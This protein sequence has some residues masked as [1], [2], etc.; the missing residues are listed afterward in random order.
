MDIYESNL[1]ENNNNRVKLLFSILATGLL[2]FTGVVVETSMNVGFPTLMKEFGV[3]TAT[4]QWITTGYLLVLSVVIPISSYLKKR[5]TLKKLFLTAV[6]LFLTGT[7]LAAFSGSFI[8]LLSGRLIQ[9]VGT[10]IALP[11]MFIIILEQSPREKAG[12]YMGLGN[13]VL[14]LAPAVGP[15]F[16][17]FVIH[18][19]TWRYVFFL[20]LPFIFI[21]LILGIWSI[22]QSSMLEKSV[23]DLRGYIVLASCFFA[24]LFALNQAGRSGWKSGQTMLLFLAAFLL[25]ILFILLEKRSEKPLLNLRV[26]QSLRFTTG[27]VA[28]MASFILALGLGF[29]LPN[30]AQI[31]LG[32]NPLR[33]GLILVPGCL[34]GAVLAPFGGKLFDRA[35]AAKPVI[36]GGI[37]FLICIGLYCLLFDHAMAGLLTMIYFLF[38]IGQALTNGNVMT[39]GLHSLS[40]PLRADGNAVYNT[41]QQLSSAVGTAVVTSIVALGQISYAKDFTTGTTIGTQHAFLFLLVMAGMFLV[42]VCLFCVNHLKSRG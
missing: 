9:G 10:G 34:I 6:L 37:L 8:M 14:A 15:S 12:F 7:M 11:L 24:F 29:L 32:E 27:A 26:F 21:S 31:V 20:L 16:G 13:M 40:E 39:V 42:V 28:L 4:V 5:F 38:P 1:P 19:F 41:F 18:L 30:Y 23:F 36:S 33:A 22:R 3:G 17:G 35:G 2:A 25:L